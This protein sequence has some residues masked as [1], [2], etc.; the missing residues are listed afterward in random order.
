M[1]VP[2]CPRCRKGG[3]RV[4]DH[5]GVRLID[6][7]RYCPRCF[8][9]VHPYYEEWQLVRGKTGLGTFKKVQK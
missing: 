2:F 7:L 4:S 6:P 8:Q 5:L 1:M 3:L 9:V